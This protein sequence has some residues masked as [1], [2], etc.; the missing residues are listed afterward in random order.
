MTQSDTLYCAVHQDR[1]AVER[2]EVCRKPLCAYCLYYTEDGQRLCQAHAEEARRRGMRIEEPSA[3]A[4]QLIGAQVGADRKE[5]RGLT[6]GDSELY[7]GNSN[8]LMAF[9]GMLVGMITLTMCCGGACLLPIAGFAISVVALLN[10][11]KSYDRR[12]TRRYAILG[13]LLS[14]VWVLLIAACFMLY[15][16]S[17]RTVFNNLSNPNFFQST[18]VWQSG[19]STYMTATPSLTPP[20]ATPNPLATKTPRS[21][22]GTPLP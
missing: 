15:G 1:I 10:I 3:Y 19:G 4:A 14:G 21:A 12:R 11:G 20:T 22:S 8:D 5:K 7:K 18:I 13:A 9:V 16:L 17:I 2:C 6:S